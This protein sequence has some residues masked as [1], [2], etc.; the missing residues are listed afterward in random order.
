MILL[1]R[2][3]NPQFYDLLFKIISFVHINKGRAESV[4]FERASASSSGHHETH[5]VTVGREVVLSA[6]TFGSP[7][8]L[9]LSGVGHKQHLEALKIPVKADLPVG[10]N[11]QDHLI[12]LL[13]VNTNISVGQPPISLF[14]QLEYKIFGTGPLG[15]PGAVDAMSFLKSSPKLDL[16][17]VQLSLLEARDPPRSGALMPGFNTDILQTRHTLGKGDGFIIMPTTM[18]LKSR[19]TLRLKSRDAQAPPMIDPNFLSEVSDLD[20]VVKSV[21][22]IEAVLNTEPMKKM[23]AKLHRHALPGCTDYDFGT[24]NYWRCFIRHVAATAH[25]P[26][27]TC[28]MGPAKDSSAVVDSRLRVK[29]VQ[30]LR[31]ADT[32]I[33]PILVSANTN[34]PTIMIGEKAADL[35]KEDNSV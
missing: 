6:G 35:I 23:N 33:M 29:G 4:E 21:R 22:L 10:D 30:G 2:F 7:Q 28:K 13:P 1:C 18:Q 15:S 25:H 16:P 26:A 9:M 14:H 20:A 12:L 19:G 11:L 24:D 17:D 8:I 3:V 27:G 31:V 32:S 5:T 34:A